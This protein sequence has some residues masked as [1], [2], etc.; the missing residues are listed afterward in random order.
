MLEGSEEAGGLKT[1]IARMALRLKPA[2]EGGA[3]GQGVLV[4]YPIALDSTPQN[5]R[6]AAES[7][8]TSMRDVLSGLGL[9]HLADSGTP[10]M[11]Y[12]VVMPSDIAGKL[13]ADG[14]FMSLVIARSNVEDDDGE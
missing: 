13:E 12:G 5:Q 7:G 14:D 9:G 1:D 11:G 2:D 6:E 4:L 10:L 8:R 3:G